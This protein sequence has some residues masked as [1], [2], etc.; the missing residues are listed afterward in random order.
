VILNSIF[1]ELETSGS[2]LVVSVL[3]TK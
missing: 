3:L 2:E 1:Y